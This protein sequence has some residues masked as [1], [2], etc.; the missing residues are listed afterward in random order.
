MK[1]L[2]MIETRGMVAAI[3]AID[4]MTKS[5]DVKLL[6][7][8]EVGGGLVSIYA[9]GEV[10]AVKAAVDAGTASAKK[11]GELISVHIISRPSDET[12]GILTGIVTPVAE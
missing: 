2:G 4:A 11:V 1:A 3:E 12:L 6:G 8:K 10:G 7:M 9:Q 5:A